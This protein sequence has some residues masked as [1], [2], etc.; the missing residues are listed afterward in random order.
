MYSDY[1]Y[2]TEEY[3]MQGSITN[4][5]YRVYGWMAAALATSAAVAYY[6]ASQPAIYKYLF[7]HTWL[8]FG[9]MIAQIALVVSLGA[10]LTRMSYPTAIVLFMVYAASLGI[11]LS[12]IFLVY[13]LPSIGLTFGVTA[14]TFG[15]MAFYGYFTKT[16]LTSWRNIG[17]MLLIGLV[18][19]FL[20]NMFLQNEMMDYI[21]SGI[22]VILFTGLTAADTQKIKQ[23][24]FQLLSHDEMMKKVA[25]I[26]AMTLYLDFVNLFLMLLRFLGKRTNE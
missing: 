13:E 7:T 1:K 18:I 11:V 19:G 16:D 25:L 3:M 14:G 22:G 9:L 20:I 5:M 10:F 24:G 8:L 15:V 12:S 4:F 21:L 6:V 26:G 17:T 23:L 2:S